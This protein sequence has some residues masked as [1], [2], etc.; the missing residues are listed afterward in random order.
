MTDIVDNL[1]TRSAANRDALQNRLT[2]KEIKTK[3]EN[4]IQTSRNNE[5][6]KKNTLLTTKVKR[7]L[8]AY[9]AAKPKVLNLCMGNGFVRSGDP[10]SLRYWT[11][12]SSI[13]G[14][15]L[16][17]TDAVFPEEGTA[18]PGP[19]SENSYDDLSPVFRDGAEYAYKELKYVFGDNTDN[20]FIELTGTQPINPVV[21][22][23]GDGLWDVTYGLAESNVIPLETPEFW[24]KVIPLQANN[25]DVL[26]ALTAAGV[27]INSYSYVFISLV[28]TLTEAA[29]NIA[30][31]P[32]FFGRV[33]ALYAETPTVRWRYGI[34]ATTT[35]LVFTEDPYVPDLDSLPVFNLLAQLDKPGAFIDATGTG[36]AVQQAERVNDYSDTELFDLFR[37][38]RKPGNPL[39]MYAI[40]DEVSFSAGLL[41]FPNPGTGTVSADIPHQGFLSR[42]TLVNYKNQNWTL[43]SEVEDEYTKYLKRN[44]GDRS[45]TVEGFENSEEYSPEYGT[46]YS[47]TLNR[48]NTRQ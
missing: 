9:P 37:K 8:A 16:I 15:R 48:T 34:A 36:Y 43:R 22:V 29:I 23:D 5:T 31:Q 24:D 10:G 2:S 13:T 40:T 14:E 33:A 1:R 45:S 26:G 38:K 41:P 4:A 28:Y 6:A 19:S 3:T 11:I 42:R 30:T 20:V 32:G 47:S 21:G 35:A 7:E 12:V 39:I 18:L 17:W 27:N 46:Y 44:V 25:T